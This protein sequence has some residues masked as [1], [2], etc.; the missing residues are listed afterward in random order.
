MPGEK[1]VEARITPRGHVT[2][3]VRIRGLLGVGRGDYLLFYLGGRSG[4]KGEAESGMLASIT[5]PLHT[6]QFP[7]GRGRLSVIAVYGLCSPAARGSLEDTPWSGCEHPN[8]FCSHPVVWIK[9]VPEPLV[10]NP[11]LVVPWPLSYPCPPGVRRPGWHL[12][13][14]SRWPYATTPRVSM[15]G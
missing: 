14:I 1:L 13:L 12:T 2:L 9:V 3:P 5:L 10:G 11:A 4:L 8:E 6:P 7:L 15:V